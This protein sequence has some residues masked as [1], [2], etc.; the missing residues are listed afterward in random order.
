M[1]NVNN[2]NEQLVLADKV[3]DAITANSIRVP[4][5]QRTL[6]WL[7]L[8]RISLQVIQRTSYA[9]IEQGFPFCNASND[10]LGLIGEL[11]PI[12]DQEKL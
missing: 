3:E 6:Q 7:A 8:E 1:A 5:F 10:T 9:L 4:P 11:K 2:E 12:G